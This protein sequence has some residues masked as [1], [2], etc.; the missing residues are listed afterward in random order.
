VVRHFRPPRLRV[1]GRFASFL[2]RAATP[3]LEEGNSSVPAGFFQLATR[4]LTRDYVPAYGCT[5]ILD[6]FIPDEEFRNSS[7]PA[8]VSS[9]SLANGDQWDLFS[10]ISDR[11]FVL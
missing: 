4:P 8:P 11:K 1:K 6:I 10:M 9:A 2:D 3:P 7:D 5:T